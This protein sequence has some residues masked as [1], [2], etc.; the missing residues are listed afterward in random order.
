MPTPLM[1]VC[2][3]EWR[4]QWR[5]MDAVWWFNVECFHDFAAACNERHYQFRARTLTG[6][7][8][9]TGHE[10]SSHHRRNKSWVQYDM[11]ANVHGWIVRTGFRTACGMMKQNIVHHAL[12]SRVMHGCI[13]GS[14]WWW[15]D[16]AGC[17]E[18]DDADN[19]PAMRLRRDD[20]DCGFVRRDM[21]G[22]DLP[23]S[24]SEGSCSDFRHAVLHLSSKLR[25]ISKKRAA[26]TVRLYFL[27][28]LFFR[29]RV[30]LL[31]GAVS[32]G[33]ERSTGNVVWFA[34]GYPWCGN[35]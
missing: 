18:W 6:S 34:H 32:W 19:M 33:A 4:L 5:H 29:P 11:F 20:D 22:R 15:H 30:T 7:A 9:R 26:V 23:L 13:G 31:D 12:K 1:I 28:F 24:P 10:S 25:L 2:R 17:G 8:I 3:S 14:A 21:P 16:R 27:F 35:L